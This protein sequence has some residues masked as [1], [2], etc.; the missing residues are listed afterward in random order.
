MPETNFGHKT[1]PSAIPAFFNQRDCNIFQSLC[2]RLASNPVDPFPGH[3][4]DETP[5]SP[6][7][8]IIPFF[9]LALH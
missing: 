6:P 4:W 3:D 2:L 7:L 5:F 1:V 8:F 9:V